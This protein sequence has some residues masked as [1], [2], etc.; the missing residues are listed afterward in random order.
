MTRQSVERSRESSVCPYCL[1]PIQEDEEQVICPVC[2]A[3]HHS[4]CWRVNGKC[5]VYGCDGWQAWNAGITDRIAPRIANDIELEADNL[6]LQPRAYDGP[7]CIECGRPV[8][9]R[10]LTCTKCRVRNLPLYNSC[11]GTSVL[12]IG[13]VFT[14]IMLIVK[15]LS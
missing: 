12:L 8:R 1:S 4:E 10:Q 2:G 14:I 13:G 5:S 7:V 15:G 6:E 9:R 11:F 3:A